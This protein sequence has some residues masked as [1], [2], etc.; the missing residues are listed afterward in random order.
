MEP[1]LSPIRV[2]GRRLRAIRLSP[3]AAGVT[4]LLLV[5][6]FVAWIVSFLISVPE[7]G[8]IGFVLALPAVG[9]AAHHTWKRF[10]RPGRIL[11]GLPVA[12]MLLALVLALME[13]PWA[14]VI[15]V[16]AAFAFVIMVAVGIVGRAALPTRGFG[17]ARVDPAFVRSEAP[18]DPLAVVLDSRGIVF[19][20]GGPEGAEIWRFEEVAAAR[21]QE[22]GERLTLRL[23]DR[24]GDEIAVELEPGSHT[25]ASKI[26]AHLGERAGKSQ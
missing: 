7:V 8:L 25:R 2:E 19:E 14:S 12:L 16:L 3:V 20:D 4:L 17:H 24:L 23:V 11:F 5:I 9:I 18:A 10:N 26:T 22:D 1:L 21:L 6:A 15:G 13:F